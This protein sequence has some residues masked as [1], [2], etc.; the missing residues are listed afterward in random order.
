[1]SFSELKAQDNTKNLFKALSS[2]AFLAPETA[3]PIEA[4]QD[5]T[6]KEIKAL[7]AE[8]KPVGLITEDGITF[9]GDSNEEEVRA[10]GYTSAVRT[11]ITETSREVTLTALEVLKENLL[12]VAY[13]VDLS[14]VTRD[15][16]TGEL[17]FDR[18][19]LPENKHWRLIVIVKDGDNYQARF[20][21]RVKL[22]AVPEEVWSA[23]DAQ[24]FELA[25]RAEHDSDLGTAERYF[26]V[27]KPNPAP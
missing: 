11:D 7:P 5:T 1:M 19:Q 2:V 14:A 4:I 22:A 10:H 23:A 9:G 26:S 27:I 25:F 15:A 6:T 16:T 20:F 12:E 13:G 17:K 21:P 3:A 18:P 8:Y 24:S